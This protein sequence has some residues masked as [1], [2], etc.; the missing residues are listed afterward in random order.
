GGGACPPWS[1]A[2][3]VASSWSPLAA[4][5]ASLGMPAK[6]SMS[7]AAP[8]DSRGGKLEQAVAAMAHAKHR[9]RV[10]DESLL[11]RCMGCPRSRYGALVPGCDQ[12]LLRPGPAGL[13]HRTGL[14]E[15]RPVALG[16][17]LVV[18]GEVE[19]E[20]AADVGAAEVEARAH[21][22]DLVAH[23]QAVAAGE[24]VG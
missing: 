19:Q 12:P 10:T 5:G 22:A 7:V 3:A 24:E 20:H 6:A 4:A 18:E 14:R 2:S 1:A 9:P 16:D 21:H 8:C 13:L 15:R 17:V 11:V 23:L